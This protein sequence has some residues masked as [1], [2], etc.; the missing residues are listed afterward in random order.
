VKFTLVVYSAPYSSQS[1]ASALRFAKTLI[2][3][4][5]DLYRLFFFGDGVHN[6]SKLAVVAQDEVNLQKQWD[7]LI[8]EHNVDSVVCV[9]SALR[10]GVLDQTETERH[11]LD[12]VSI[13]ESSEIAGLGQLIDATLKSDRVINFG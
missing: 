13:Y 12:A 6:A 5:H 8:S 3:Q 2:R 7:D 1:A 10:R 9:S 11:E 4:G